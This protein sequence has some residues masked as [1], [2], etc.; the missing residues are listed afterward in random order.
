MSTR[1]TPAKS[2]PLSDTNQS[3]QDGQPDPNPGDYTYF[4]DE[5]ITITSLIQAMRSAGLDVKVLKEEFHAGA[6]DEEW[7]P[8]AIEKGWI[9]L[10]KDDRWRFRP[11]EKEILINAS[12]R[13]FVFVSKSARAQEIVETI[14]ACLGKMAKIIE[15]EPAPFVAHILLSRHVSVVFPNRSK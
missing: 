14:M 9:L 12:A 7:L 3:A 11:A 8:V 1:A 6:L 10:T 4:L 13:V 15:S 2:K 5:S